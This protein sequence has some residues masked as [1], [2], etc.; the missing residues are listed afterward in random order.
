MLSPY[1]EVRDEQVGWWL[2]PDINC[3][4]WFPIVAASE[5]NHTVTIAGDH[6]ALGT[7]GTRFRIYAPP[8]VATRGAQAGTLPKFAEAASSRCL[9]KGYRYETA[10]AGRWTSQGIAA[11]Q[12]GKNFTGQH[13]TLFR[14]FDPSL[15]RFTSLD[16]IAASQNL[17]AY[18]DNN[19]HGSYDPDG[20]ENTP[21]GGWFISGRGYGTRWS[22]MVDGAGVAAW[23]IVDLATRPHTWLYGKVSGSD[24]TLSRHV[25]LSREAVAYVNEQRGT[26]WNYQAA[27]T[28]TKTTV[29]VAAGAVVGAYALA[30]TTP[31]LLA[32]ASYGAATPAVAGSLGWGAT[33]VAGM[34]GGF[35]GGAVSGGLLALFDGGGWRE[36]I[37]GAGVGGVIGGALGFL[38]EVPG[39]LWRAMRPVTT[40]RAAAG[41]LNLMGESDLFFQNAKFAKPLCGTYDVIG[42][43]FIRSGVELEGQAILGARQL[44]RMILAQPDYT[45]GQAVRLISCHT[46]N[47]GSRSFAQ[48][49]SNRLNAT[50]YAPD[51]LVFAHPGGRL[52]IGPKSDIETGSWQSFVPKR[53]LR[54]GKRNG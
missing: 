24:K 30:A 48:A 29:A 19:P 25:G 40:S 46:G 41:S 23:D 5:S 3:Q 51:D 28:V 47:G 38:G 50:V 44:A 22:G 18:C 35:A 20:L 52:T 43:S 4:A 54:R 16:P 36:T 31:A 12:G 17:W 10:A 53:A 15:M 8:G 27:Q 34:T 6:R 1:A 33:A 49:L 14:H 21:G 45:R 13:Y 9:Y 42:H 7:V 11:R 37:A 32:M 2:Q 26:T 39:G